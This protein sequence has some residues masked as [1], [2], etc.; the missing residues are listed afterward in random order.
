VANLAALRVGRVTPVG[1]VGDDGAGLELTRALFAAGVDLSRVARSRS[2]PTPTYAKPV[3]FEEPGQPPRELSRFDVFPRQPLSAADEKLLLTAA[4]ETLAGC[5]ALIISDYG[6][7]GKAE[8]ITPA[9]RAGLL[10][11]RAENPG[12]VFFVD[13]RLKIGEFPDC[14]IKPNAREAA[15]L[16]GGEL[17][18]DS[19]LDE[20]RAAAAKLVARAGRPVFLTLG[21]RGMLA[22]APGGVTHVP[23]FAMTGPIDPVGA[24]DA[25]TASV[26]AA[27]AAGATPADA[28]LFGVLASSV[29]VG[30]VGECG[31][32]RPDEV[33][34]RFDEYAAAHPDALGGGA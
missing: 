18:E 26:T 31:T 5:E 7:A 8:L 12:K 10:E 13:S 9:V 34:E 4:R 11:L 20:L 14:S 19:P 15:E 25:V 32:A 3:I 33:R 21:E 17:A 27:L 28:A 22:A 2:R 30:K 6:E 23:G 24:G 29:T 16:L 1:F